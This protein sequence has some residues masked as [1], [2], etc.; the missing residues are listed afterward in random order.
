[1]S[2]EQNIPE[3]EIHDNVPSGLKVTGDRPYRILMMAS[4]TG[5]SDD[6]KVNAPLTDGVVDVNAESFDDVM[7]N[8]CPSV[9]F[10]INDPTATGKTAVS[11]SAAFESLKDF[12]PKQLARKL[13]PTAPLMEV[14]DKLV[15]RLTG[16]ASDDDVKKT[17]AAASGSG[18]QFAWLADSVKW[19]PTGQGAD[20]AD[21]GDLMGSLDFGEGG[22]DTDAPPPKSDVGRIVSSA[23]QDGS[24]ISAEEASATRR[25]LAEIDRRVSTW[26]TTLLHSPE[27][28][29]IES[30]W[31]SLA[32]LVSNVDFRKG[33]RMALL[34]AKEAD[35]I[36]CFEE[37]LLDPIYEQGAEA[38]DVIV[39]DG[40]YAVNAA[41]MEMLSHFAEGAAGLPALV[42]AGVGPGFFG[43]KHAWQMTTLPAIPNMFQQW[44]FAKWNSLRR[45]PISHSLGV[46]FGRG[47]L[48]APY[49]RSHADDLEFDYREENV[50]EKDF[51]W[52]SGAV[53][54]ALTTARSFAESGWPTQMSGLV[55]GSV[56]GFHTGKGGKKGDKVYGPTDTQ[57]P[58]PK[59]NEMGAI[60]VNALVGAPEREDAVVWNGLTAL[61]PVNFDP[62]GLMEVSL[63]SRL[64][65]S[66]LSA[67]LFELK[68][69]LAGLDSDRITG[70]VT[71]HI[72]SWLGIP[73]PTGEDETLR[74]QTRPAEDDPTRIELAVT[75]VPPNNIVPNGA[76]AVVGYR[77]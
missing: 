67:L 28:Q 56:E 66:R 30:A 37:K 31:R 44:Q 64:F 5:S 4:F 48:R 14:R 69:H 1:M 47:M 20:S 62:E 19:T 39:L 11:I 35:R 6:G 9:Q 63:P 68:P 71:L 60:G 76:P 57:L 8:A 17:V 77:I 53:A 58:Q 21:I 29:S 38:P 13:S 36:D 16:K 27:I 46:V 59:I 22:S 10:S 74:V 41:D 2:D 15:A 50:G 51:L 40:Q 54:A 24:S 26:L 70:M 12:D 34:H 23:A 61:Q 55:S 43:I 32:F 72:C 73:A 42:Y 3:L 75:V 25:T 7:R 33:I 49:E 52:L 45:T 65:A 18:P